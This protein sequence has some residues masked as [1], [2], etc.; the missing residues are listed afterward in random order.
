VHSILGGL[1]ASEKHFRSGELA[2]AT[3]V[4][5]DTLR[6]YERL[7]LLPR[8][9]RTRSNYRQ[10]AP[11]AVQR[12]QLIQRALSVG[13]SLAELTRVLRVRDAGGAPCR[14]VRA[15]AADK[16][17]EIDRRLGE[18]VAMRQ[19]LKQLIVDWD[20]RLKR[21]PDGQRAGLLELLPGS[22][23]RSSRKGIKI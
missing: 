9:R 17:R 18:L 14:Q 23:P 16:L 15:L 21:T 8:P 5:R 7:G 4:S 13:F 19:L 20:E 22:L 1:K 10:Y 6:H 12:V 11:D 3:G 2:E